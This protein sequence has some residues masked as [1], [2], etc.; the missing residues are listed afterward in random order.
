MAENKGES[1]KFQREVSRSRS[2]TNSTPHKV[3]AFLCSHL[4]IIL[5]NRMQQLFYEVIIFWIRIHFKTIYL[6]RFAK[7]KVI[8]LHILYLYILH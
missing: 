2:L 8:H 5:L 7:L 1:N 6:K 4:S 3:G